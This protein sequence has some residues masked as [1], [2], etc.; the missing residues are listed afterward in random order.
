MAVY[1]M[2]SLT[3]STAGGG[4]A[5]GLT[6]D[7]IIISDS[8]TQN[9]NV[10]ETSVDKS[11]NSEPDKTFKIGEL[12][13][14]IG[15]GE[16]SVYYSY[17]FYIKFPEKEVAECNMCTEASLKNNFPDPRKKIKIKGGNTKGLKTHLYSCHS[18]YV[19]LY[20]Q[21]L[22]EAEELSNQK[23]KPKANDG[24]KQQTLSGGDNKQLK[25]DVKDYGDLQKRY[26]DGL[27]RYAAKTFTSFRA[28]EHIDIIVEAIKPG[29]GKI[30]K[31]GRKFISK[32]TTTVYERI[33][34]DIMSILFSAKDYCKSFAFTSDI[35]SNKRQHSFL[36]LT[37]HFITP[38]MKL[39]KLVPYVVY[40]GH[41]RHTGVNIK[42]ALEKMLKE[43]GMDGPDITRYICLDN[44]A[45]NK[46]AVRL[47]SKFEAMWCTNHTLNL[48]VK[49]LYKK[50]EENVETTK[51]LKKCK[52]LAKSVRKSG[53]QLDDLS[54]ACTNT[55]TPNILPKKSQ[56]TRWNSL[57]DCMESVLRL[58]PAFQYLAA[59]D[60]DDWSG[61]TLSK[62]EAQAATALSKILECAKVATKLWEK[63]REPSIH[64]V[65]RELWNMHDVLD[66]YSKS[67]NQNIA[68]FAIE[69]KMILEKRF[70]NCGTTNMMYNCG[71]FFDPE[72]RGLILKEFPGVYE[73][74]VEYIKKMSRKYDTTPAPDSG[75]ATNAV[76][77][78]DSVYNDDSVSGA[79]KLKRRK[80]AVS[81][82]QTMTRIDVELK[83]YE[84]M[85][86]SEEDY[87]GIL[88]FWRRHLEMFAAT[89][90]C[91]RE[92]LATPASSSSS[93][94]A[95]SIGTKVCDDTRTSLAPVK[96]SE[97][98]LI[99][100]GEK[101][102]D[103]YKAEYTIPKRYVGRK[104]T[105]LVEQEM[106]P[107]L[108]EMEDEFYDEFD[109][110]DTEDFEDYDTDT[111]E[112]EEEEYVEDVG[113]D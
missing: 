108:L 8:D 113:D 61:K 53:N 12:K 111:D 18:N 63:D 66:N 41:N 27:V 86:I 102:V 96:I 23:P 6:D 32:H 97:L 40:F 34:A 4:S 89:S 2:N 43:L 64:Y 37:V 54:D 48:A 47:S 94:R 49:D 9:N 82:S 46:C 28:L 100:I 10:T 80:I 45:N 56:N 109:V 93:E 17:Q 98:M 1:I 74:T 51:V 103:H 7:P 77:P 60:P 81:S 16:R 19:A 112:S 38:D 92:V 25:V 73:A 87:Q 65:I 14:K 55:N 106:E 30:K 22:K 68:K 69:F 70:P 78:E 90:P 11:N 101:D 33:S 62:K 26:D 3:M 72:Y 99:N 110:T 35:W 88:D 31:R 50:T 15:S 44:A 76:T 59:S 21:R 67:S 29:K 84:T 58:Q 52:A 42:L 105:Q 71:H 85:V 24:M 79:Q 20:E 107:R 39:V 75:V 91:V 57:Q 83:N 95:F 5:G 13:S 36:S 104:V